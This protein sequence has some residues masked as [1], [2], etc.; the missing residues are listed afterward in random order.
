MIDFIVFV[1]A[2][3]YA[4]L[5]LA[6]VIKEY[7]IGALASMGLTVAGIYIF[8]SGIGGV[9]NFLTDAIALI[10]FAIGV[11]ILIRATGEQ[12]VEELNGGN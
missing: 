2:F 11:Y 1:L 5:V 4:M 12:A 8:M 10:T 9:N 3:L 6:F 7:A